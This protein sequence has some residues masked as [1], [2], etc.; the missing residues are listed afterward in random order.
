MGKVDQTNKQEKLDNF[1]NLISSMKF[2]LEKENENKT[3]FLDVTIA[4]EYDNISFD[5]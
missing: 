3:N 5:I 1:N 4:K 2:T